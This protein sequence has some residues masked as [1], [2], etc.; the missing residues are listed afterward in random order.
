MD[1]SDIRESIEQLGKLKE[2]LYQICDE[3][4]NY[5][6]GKGIQDERRIDR[7]MDQILS[8]LEED[9]FSSLFWRLV[10]YV[11][12]FDR[13]LGEDYRKMEREVTAEE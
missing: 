1:F 10:N 4:V 9:K 5:I 7:V 11:E 13:E 3:E 2:Q 12:T 6:I 8:Y